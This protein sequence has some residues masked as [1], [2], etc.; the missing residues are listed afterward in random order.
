MRPEA[1]RFDEMTFNATAH[2]RWLSNHSGTRG[3][4]SLPVP[5][6]RAWTDF[7]E[8]AELWAGG[9]ADMLM[10]AMS[11]LARCRAALPEERDAD[12][13]SA[14]QEAVDLLKRQTTGFREMV[15]FWEADRAG[16]VPDED[17]V[18]LSAALR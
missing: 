11:A 18:A 17:A 10:E 8:A 13:R 16:P 6:L 4:A 12:P 14:R 2:V 9:R 1:L 5:V 7:R 3:F 15:A